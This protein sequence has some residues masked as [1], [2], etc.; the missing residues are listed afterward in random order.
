MKLRGAG[1]L[2]GSVVTLTALGTVAACDDGEAAGVGGG[3]SGVLLP[4]GGGADGTTSGQTDGSTIPPADSGGDSSQADA[5]LP[6]QC[7]DGKVD[8]GETCDPLDKCPTDCPPDGCNLRTLENGGTCTA[9]CTVVAVQTQCQNS[10]GCC[11]TGCSIANDNDCGAV[12]GN[13]V[14]EAGETCDGADCPTDCAPVGCQLRALQNPGTC[15]AKCVDASK[16]TTC[17]AVA[18]GGAATDNCCPAGC[19]GTTDP[20]CKAG[21]CGNNTVDPGETCDTG[22]PGSCKTDC[23]AQA[24]NLFKL[25]NPGTCQAACVANGQIDR[26]INAD[27]CC[28]TGCDN[29]NDS[30]C[31][32]KCGNGVIEPPTEE[33]DANCPTSCA[34]QGCNLVKLTNGGT[35]QAKCVA[36]GEQQTSCINADGCCPPGCTNTNDND[37]APPTCGN[38]KLDVGET[39]D[40]SDP[41]HPCPIC[42]N[43]SVTCR[44]STGSASQ[45]NL[46]CD[47][48]IGKCSGKVNDACCPF[49]AKDGSECSVS[50]DNDCQGRSWSSIDSKDTLSLKDGAC[51]DIVISNV[52]AGGAYDVTTCSPTAVAK[53]DVVIKSVTGSS[54]VG[55]GPV[56]Q[57]GPIILPPAVIDYGSNDNCLDEKWA[58]PYR[59]GYTC[60]NLDGKVLMACVAEGPGGFVAKNA[61]DLVVTV[62]AQGGSASFPFTLFYNARATPTITVK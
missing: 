4:D 50:S 38:G 21:A 49:A 3:D 34:Q 33:C 22:I 45:C 32:P 36:T 2:I 13:G 1:W 47:V 56:L 9:T 35:C 14:K 46:K 48:P 43:T 16:I 17:G 26:C 59:A 42:N 27:G 11:P 31:A 6:A 18:D 12:C 60:T 23:P 44:G 55:G 29:T 20:D 39:C 40:P 37:C 51:V 28:P 5:N 58:L 7:N 62:C 61:S 25:E 30:D 10:D 15:T 19:D 52:E 8:L 41:A 57:A 53:G 24:C 54:A